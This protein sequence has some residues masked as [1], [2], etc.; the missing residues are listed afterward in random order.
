MLGIGKKLSDDQLREHMIDSYFSLRVG[1]AIIG[2]A[3]PIVLL[4]IAW[5]LGWAE[6]PTSMSGYY[7]IEGPARDVFVG[8]LFAVAALL[9][10]YKG[11][12][13]GENLLLNT[14]AIMAMLVALV[15][16]CE[17]CSRLSWHI[18]FSVTFF[19]CIACVA[20][21]CSENTL[22]HLRQV[23]PE[24]ATFYKTVYSGTA[25]GMLIG[26][27]LAY[28]LAPTEKVFWAEALGVWMFAAF[29][30]FKTTELRAS[31]IDA[32]FTGALAP[33]SG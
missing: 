7:L 20:A 17:D 31:R 25:G 32:K 9:W 6:R 21:F 4:V 13:K 18:T 10:V 26:P 27:A 15:P 23:A 3:L 19:I 11:Y 33:S 5:R 1:M 28:L 12:G 29:W 14:A 22:A 30:I 8:G 16:T 24:R 2:V